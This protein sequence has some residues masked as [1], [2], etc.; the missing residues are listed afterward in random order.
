M[1]GALQQNNFMIPSL[2]MTVTWTGFFGD[3]GDINLSSILSASPSTLYNNF[4]AI[5]IPGVLDKKVRVPQK[6][7]LPPD[8][9]DLDINPFNY[10]DPRV[11]LHDVLASPSC[12]ILFCNGTIPTKGLYENL[13]AIARLFISKI[14]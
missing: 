1:V 9:L 3:E 6:G 8:G 14:P 11:L 12:N 13:Q 7:D 2:D 10:V 5:L 4:F